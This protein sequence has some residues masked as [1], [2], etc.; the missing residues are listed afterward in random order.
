MIAL[1]IDIV[2]NIP[3]GKEQATGP[4]LMDDGSQWWEDEGFANL[5][6]GWLRTKVEMK[7]REKVGL[8]C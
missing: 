5:C 4:W 7:L 1:V 8:A 6:D 3:A 2:F